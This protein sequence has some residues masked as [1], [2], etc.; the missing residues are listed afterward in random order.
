M[1]MSIFFNVVSVIGVDEAL[2]DVT[3]RLLS[4]DGIDF[5]STLSIPLADVFSNP[6]VTVINSQAIST[7]IQ[8]CPGR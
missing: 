7:N 6:T 1:S 2:G 4:R 8:L 3:G 5:I